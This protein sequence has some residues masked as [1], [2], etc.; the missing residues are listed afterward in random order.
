MTKITHHLMDDIKTQLIEDAKGWPLEK[1]FS[2][3]LAK[4]DTWIVKWFNPSQ[5]TPCPHILI[6]R[7]YALV[8]DATEMTYDF[9]GYI[10]RYVTDKPLK[11]ASTHAHGDHTLANWQFNDCE[12]YMSEPAWEEI[13]K[14][15]EQEWNQPRQRGHQ[16]GDYVPTILKPGDIIDLGGRRLEVLEYNPCHSPTSLIYLDLTYGILF[17]GDEIDPGQINIWN[18]SVE[19]FRNNMLGLK[20]RA[21]DFDMICSPHNGSPQHAKILDYYIE[22]CDRIMSGIEGDMDKGS[23]SYLLNPFEPRS[24][25]TV[26]Q[27]RFDPQIR[28][29]VWKGT[30]IN[31]NIDLIWDSQLEKGKE[32]TR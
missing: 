14:S 6:G 19:T 3:R 16:K 28:R 18:T 4:P 31:Y 12:I 8:I 29:S 32:E 20:A 25:E 11:V 30:A 2:L 10:E 9:R 15:R 22:N 5:D 23:M 17:P 24:E 7:D 1:Q 27:R 26:K 13:K 21:D